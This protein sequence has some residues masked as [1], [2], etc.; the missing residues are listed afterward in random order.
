M[1]MEEYK[2][3]VKDA[4]DGDSYSLFCIGEAYR[5]GYAFDD[6]Y[7]VEKNLFKAYEYHHKAAVQGFPPAVVSTGLD[8]IGGIGVKKDKKKGYEYLK[9]IS[10]FYEDR[11]DNHLDDLIAEASFYIGAGYHDGEFGFFGK[12]KKAMLY[13]ERASKLGYAEA[14]LL[15]N[16]LYY[17][18]KGVVHDLDQCIF[19]A[20]CAYLHGKNSPEESTKGRQS[21]EFFINHG[22][23]GG[24]EYV[25][26]IIED[27]KCNYKHYTANP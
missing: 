27:V 24:K 23:P 2:K 26:G 7:A 17:I 12:D 11:K 10:D 16:S 15:L 13:L 8:L 14:Q 3:L 6:G 22:I 25:D 19:W 20:A 9:L 1:T 18:G 21:L 4:E 5:V